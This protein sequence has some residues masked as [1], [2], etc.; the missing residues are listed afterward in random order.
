METSPLNWGIVCG[1]FGVV[2][3]RHISR[4][5]SRFTK[6]SRYLAHRGPDSS[7][8]LEFPGL[9]AGMH[10]LAING[11][12]SGNQPIESANGQVSLMGNGEVYNSHIL[13]SSLGTRGL[14]LRSDSDLAPVVELWADRGFGCLSQI[15]G[16]YALAVLDRRSK[17]V[18]L[19]RDRM[20]EKPLYIAN[21]GG[22]I[23]WSSEVLPLIRAGIVAGGLNATILERYLIEGVC[24]EPVTPI[25]GIQALEPGTALQIHIPTL[26]TNVSEYWRP[27]EFLGENLLRADDLAEL[28]ENS[29]RNALMSDVP[30]AVALSAGVDSSYVAAIARKFRRDIAAF[31][32]DFDAGKGI[33]EGT[34]ASLTARSLGIPHTRLQVASEGIADSFLSVCV[35]R[36]LPVADVTGPAYDALCRDVSG[37]GA[38]VLLTGQGA[39][40]LF[41]GYNWATRWVDRVNRH[42]RTRRRRLFPSWVELERPTG[43]SEW[44]ERFRDGF[45]LHS[46]H[47]AMAL[48]IDPQL[49]SNPLRLQPKWYRDRRAIRRLVQGKA[50]GEPKTVLPERDSG[51]VASDLLLGMLRTYLRSNGLA[52]LDRLSMQHGLEVRTPFVDRALVEYVLGGAARTVEPGATAAKDFFRS[53][54]AKQLPAAVLER[55]KSGFLPPVRV[56]LEK[57]WR[58]TEERRMEP[59][60]PAVL[61]WDKGVAQEILKAPTLVTGEVNHLGLRLLTLEV[62]LREV[63]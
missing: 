12:L 13:R 1:I 51:V 48:R 29:V 63:V 46:R 37:A 21:L 34:F 11:L 38:K 10:R 6:L 30:V 60:S 62:W 4:F 49:S 14:S 39:D 3:D 44:A 26:G 35:S 58:R 17:T 31:T 20:G 19:V 22:E 5:D 56:W 42:Q 24:S 41:W 28:L 18:T 57:I 45:G 32:V 47:A 50:Q 52:Q 15:D 2:S 9:L 23:W 43:A 7:G 59:I 8:I 40:E 55:P 53:V 54:V 27:E 61:G 33:N 16:M 25:A 36:D